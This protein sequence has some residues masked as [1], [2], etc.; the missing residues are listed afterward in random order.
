MRSRDT[1]PAD[2][3]GPTPLYGECETP[4]CEAN[5]RRTCATCKAHVCLAHVEHPHGMSA[6]SARTGNAATN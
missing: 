2:K 1:A 4:D 6:S 5:A 3:Y